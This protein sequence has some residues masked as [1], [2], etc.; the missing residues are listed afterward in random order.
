MK[1]ES[2]P[3]GGKRADLLAGCA[4]GLFILFVAEVL[5]GL[6]LEM[7]FSA[8]YDS[9]YRDV[10]TLSAGFAMLRAF[11]Y[12]SSSILIAGSFAVIICM[13]AA[14]WFNP[15]HIRM[16]TATW[17]LFLSS[18][19][20][21][22]S[23]N[24]LPFDKH[25]VQTAVIEAGVARQFP[26]GNFVS[27]LMLAGDQFNDQTIQRWHVGHIV[28]PVLGIFAA[29]LFWSGSR[30][31]RQSKAMAWAPLVLAGL[32][33]LM[34]PAPLGAQASA[35]DYGAYDAQVSWYTWPLHGALNLFSRISPSLGWLGGG[36]LPGLFAVFVL[37]APFIARR[38]PARV[39][40]GIFAGFCAVF[41]FAALFFGGRPAPLTGNRD[42]VPSTRSHIPA[43]PVDKVLYA[44]GRDFFNT[45]GCSGCH[46]KDGRNPNGSPNLYGIAAKLGSDPQWYM[47]FI[48]EPHSVKPTST[49]PPFPHLKEDETRAIAE[50]LIHQK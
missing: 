31:E 6:V 14:R 9:A 38:L 25:G 24:V 22:L 28:F 49:M 35:A 20:A 42:P 41:L 23:G 7:R 18:L 47:K 19:F 36:L 48:H 17:L 43:T 50:F 45:K 26:G 21:Q 32:A 29:W 10:Q 11:H 4:A 8:S 3:F 12:W 13:L 27:S 39:V 40:Q 44:K 34:A 46:G 30:G 37:A 33:M 15:G 5:F 1:A 2:P 16:W